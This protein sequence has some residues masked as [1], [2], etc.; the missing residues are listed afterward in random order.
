MPAHIHKAPVRDYLCYLTKL[1]S[2]KANSRLIGSWVIVFT[3]TV[4]A[5]VDVH[6]QNCIV[7]PAPNT[8]AGGVFAH[9]RNLS[10]IELRDGT[11]Q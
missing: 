6:L 10:A 4:Y 8:K 7:V 2:R 1:N 3:G 11:C 5:S 9:L